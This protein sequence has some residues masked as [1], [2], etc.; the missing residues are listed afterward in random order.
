MPFNFG[1]GELVFVL[2]I[3]GMGTL[4]WFSLRK[5]TSPG[6]GGKKQCSQCG[7][8]VYSAAKFCRFCGTSF[9]SGGR[10]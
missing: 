4:V 3:V 9:P 7:E 5:A 10:S 6:R 2:V 8:F 1:A